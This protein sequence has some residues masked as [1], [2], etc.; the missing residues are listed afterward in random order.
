ML[1]PLSL[2]ISSI[3]TLGVGAAIAPASAALPVLAAKATVPEIAYTRFTLPNGL[4]VVVHED[5]KAP[6]V[7]VSIW[8]HIG[9]GDEPAGKTGF[10]HLFEHLMFSGSENHKGSYFQPFEKVGANDMNGTTGSDRTNYFE[11][12]PTTALDLALWM[13]SDRMGHLLGAIG[14][15]ELD[16]QRGVVQNEKRQGENAP[17]GRVDENILANIFP[18]NHPYQH[19]T[20]GSMADLDAASLYDVKQW[21]HDNYGAANTT[22]VLAGDITVAQAQAKAAQY[23]GDIPAGKPVPRQQPWITPLARQTRGVQH[24]HVAQPR[25]YRTWVAPQLGSDD[26]VQLDLASNV[27]GG[28]KTSRLYQRLVYR[29]NLVDDVSASIQPFALASQLQIVA[30]VRDGADPAKVEAAIAD[31]LKKFLAEGPSA[32]ELQRAQVASRAGFVR[33]LEKVGGFTGKAAILAEGQVYRNDPGAYQHDLQRAQAATVASV[34]KAAD[35]WFGKGDYLL[36]VLPAGDGFDP[37]AEDK[38]VKPLPVAAGKPAPKLLTKASY[39]VGK[40]QVDRAAGIPETSQFPS[41]SFPQLQ[42][43]KLKNGIEVVLA[44]RHTIPVTQVE[45]LFDAGY[46]ADQGGKLGTAN[47]TAA[48]MNESTRSLDSVEVAQRRQRL[49][50]ITSVACEL[51]S[52]AASLD[53][54][55][56]QLAPSLALFADIVRNPAFKAEDIERIRG[57]WLASIAQ[58]KTEPQDLALRILPPL[59]YGPQHPYG[60][61]LTGSGTEAAIKSLSASDLAAFQNTWLRPD[62]LRILVA[63]DTTL[64]Q[65][66][67]QLDAAFGDW[68]PPAATRPSKTLAQVAAQPKPRVFLINRADAPQSLILAGLLAPSNKAPNNIVI[69]VAN[70]AF[71]GDFTSRLNM[72]LREDKRWSYGAYTFMLD[73]QG[74]RP[75][76][77]SAPVQTDKTAESAAEILKEAKAVVGDKPLTAEEIANSKTQRIRALPG[78]FETT[79]AVLG[80]V[81]RIVQ[82]GRPD[83]YVQTLKTHMEGIDQ[84]AAQAAIKAIVAPQAMTWVIV[85]DLKQIEAPVRALKLGQVQ[86]LDSDGQPVKAKAKA[87]AKQ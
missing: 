77:F 7:A 5:H 62:N 14:Q 57:Q 79:D 3:L 33:G 26:A 60:V 53:A 21:F 41:L 48:L 11:T 76:L 34:R 64:G 31:E 87:T 71:G 2:L 56:D 59:L 55:N 51:D 1:R 86:V 84:A 19:T 9:S 6:V 17:Y 85:G 44:E 29:D 10:A 61:P 72:N 65:I 12:V 82:Y 50:A 74:Q 38:A 47:F 27:L 78:S 54:L 73:T 58:E 81:E 52:C 16:T 36:T 13:E 83:D 25:I 43:G 75:F 4:T 46:A 8:Y 15:K 39:S 68:Q 66:I 37:A 23:F 35:T 63:G 80:M 70:G 49:G 32:D 30:D 67:P 24:D 18:A 42:R 69:G 22:L 45:L 20:I 28:G 40:N